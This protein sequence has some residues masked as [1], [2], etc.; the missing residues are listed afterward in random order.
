TFRTVH[1]SKGLEAD[2]IVLPNLTRGTYGFPSQIQ[3]DP[4][5]AL[6]MTGDDGYRHSEERRLFYVALT[7]AR[8]GVTIFTVQGLE[9]PFVV[10]LL[11]DPGILLQD[12]SG[13]AAPVRVC[14]ACGQGILTVRPS[15][16]G[17]FYGCSRF[18]A[19]GHKV[20]IQS[21]GARPRTH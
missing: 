11:S 9:S 16:Y 13:P 5:L 20:R 4:V 14:P 8:R 10:E 3:D 12:E 19:C 17:E 18:P 15:R 1:Q 6:A 2:F 7:R 21:M